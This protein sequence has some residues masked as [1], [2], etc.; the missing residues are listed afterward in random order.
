MIAPSSRLAKRWLTAA[1]SSSADWPLPRTDQS[2]STGKAS[3]AFSPMPEKLNPSTRNEVSTLSRDI[4]NASS[5]APVA[6]VRARVAPGGNCTS[7]IM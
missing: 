4:R 2:L 1:I 6:E 3:A 7:T 5:S